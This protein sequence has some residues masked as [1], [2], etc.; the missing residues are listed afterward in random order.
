MVWRRKEMQVTQHCHNKS[1]TTSI[2]IG[3]CLLV[4][5]KLLIQK[6]KEDVRH[7][8][9]RPPTNTSSQWCR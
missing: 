3:Y 4:A 2:Q 9:I 8:P 1:C 6:K 7:T 5:S